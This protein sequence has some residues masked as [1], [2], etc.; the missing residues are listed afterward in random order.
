MLQ[1]KIKRLLSDKLVKNIGWLSASQILIRVFRLATVVVLARKL[2]TEDYGVIA[3]L[4][5]VTD[6]ASIFLTKG[7]IAPKLIQADAEDLEVLANTAYW[8]NWIL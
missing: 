6:F 3:I 4:F 7:G 1:E 2:S 5:T 8:V